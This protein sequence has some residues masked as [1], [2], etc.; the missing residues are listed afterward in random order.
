MNHR[1]LKRQEKYKRKE[2]IINSLEEMLEREACNS[3]TRLSWMRH[4]EIRQEYQEQTRW[5]QDHLQM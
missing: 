4:R 1:R 5:Q 3:K 2:K